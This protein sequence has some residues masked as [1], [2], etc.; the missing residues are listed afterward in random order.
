MLCVEAFGQDAPCSATGPILPSVA[1]TGFA[2]AGTDPTFNLQDPSATDLK[3]F[4]VPG[5][6][7]LFESANGS[8]TNR[9]SWSDVLEFT[10]GRTSS[11]ATVFPDLDPGIQLPPN[12]VLSANFRGV[13]EVGSTGTD[14]DFTTYTAGSNVYNV[15]SDSPLFETNDPD[16]PEPSSLALMGVGI[17]GAGL[18]MRLRARRVNR[19]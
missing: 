18:T 1:G 6:V 12:F 10:T 19:S 3:R 13:M 11:T 9:A 5:D 8:S 15:Y 4:V 2:I 16:V 14:A 17:L 7:I